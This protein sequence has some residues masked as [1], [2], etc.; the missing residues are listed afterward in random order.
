MPN[1]SIIILTYNNLEFTKACIES[2]KKYTEPGTYEIIVVDNKSKDDTV[3]YLKELKDITLICNEQNEGFPKGCNIGISHAQKENDI[4]LLNNDTIVTTNWL[5]NLKIALYSSKNIGASG[6]V[7]N[8]QENLQGCDFTYD[9][10]EIM[11]EKAKVNNQ[12]NPQKWEE[13]VCLIGYCLLIKRSVFNLIGKLDENYS[14]GYIEDNDLSLSIIEKGYKLLLCHDA[15]IHHYLGTEFRRDT[16]KF[17]QLILKNRAYFESVWHFNVFTFDET[18]NASIFLAEN[19]Q[20]VLN[21]K[22][23]IGTSSLRIKYLFPEAKITGLEKDIYQK[24]IAE[25]FHK[26]Y[27]KLEDLPK[28]A[29]DTIFIGK[30]LEHA[31]APLI[32]LHQLKTYLKPNGTIIGEVTNISNIENI[33][34]L[35]EDHWYYTNFE[36]KNHF[37]KSDLLEIFKSL[38][39]KNIF[40]YSYQK[41]L[42]DKEQELASK[43]SNPNITTTYYAFRISL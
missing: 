35:I 25:H 10:F 15:F 40:I 43:L 11:Q 33:T 36:K 42:T 29:F 13:K 3:S 18:R 22:C 32:F 41:E 24:R 20:K 5:K 28:K 1:T 30:E 2:I 21:I 23:G 38:N 19:P 31:N 7:S 17:N 34:L 37:T 39:F 14:P 4:L 8:H 27:E 9:T 12:S 6:A 26:V 16:E